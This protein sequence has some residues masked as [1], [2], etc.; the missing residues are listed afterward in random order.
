MFAKTKTVDIYLPREDS[1]LLQSC[2]PKSLKGRKVLEIG[3]GSGILAITAAKAGAKVTAVDINADA[4]ELAEINARSNKVRV[5]FAK[6]DLFY[7][8]KGRYDLIINNPP[9]LPEDSFDE[10]VG[11]SRMYSGGKSGRVFIEKFIAQAG[12]FLK[13]RGKI[14]M[15]ISS[16]TGEL[17]VRELFK[18]KGFHTRVIARQK[19]PWEE[20]IVIEATK[21]ASF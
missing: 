4:L 15:V 9:Y 8:V 19:I 7:S 12:K 5:T 10:V 3:T 2:I 17:Q 11:P 18:S 13:P 1:F 20:L 14:L 6:S 16:L 21:Q